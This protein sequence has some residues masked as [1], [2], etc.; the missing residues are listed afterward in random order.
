[1]L[2]KDDFEVEAAAIAP[3]ADDSLAH[4]GQP[5]WSR[6]GYAGTLLWN[7]AA[8]LLPALY[9]TLSKLWVANIDSSMVVTTDAYTYI[10]VVVEVLNEGLPRAA[11]NIIGDKSNRS[12]AERHQLSYTLVGIQAVLGLIM[13]V[14]FVAAAQQFADAFVPTEVRAASL[15]YV[16]ISAFSAFSSAIQYAVNNATRALDYPDVPLL[17]SCVQFAVN[18]ILDFI[19]ISKFH[20]SGV[21]PTV[22]L[23]AVNQ[24]A[25]S[26][27]AAIV[28]LV[29]FV[30]ITAR[31]RR[32]SNE[33]EQASVRPSW[34]ALLVLRP[35]L[36]RIC[37]P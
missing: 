34:K 29:Y 35:Y 32:V 6:Q 15:T 23:Q 4:Q 22:N 31:E 14:C 18:I 26:M 8:F 20:V 24:L 37:N 36:H 11:W 10:G 16:R 1:M 17:M 27:A 33:V 3:E 7:V 28:G 12:T 30:I 9:G 25:C 5:R 2:P 21:K 13:S 19:I